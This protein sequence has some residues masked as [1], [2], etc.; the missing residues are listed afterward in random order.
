MEEKKIIEESIISF[1]EGLKTA[2]EIEGTPSSVEGL[3]ELFL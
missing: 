2:P 3:D 1:R